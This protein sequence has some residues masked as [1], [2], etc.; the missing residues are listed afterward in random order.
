[1]VECDFRR[2][3]AL[4]LAESAKRIA[5]IGGYADFGVLSG[6]G[7]SQVQGQE[8]PAIVIPFINGPCAPM[9]D[10]AYHR[11]SPLKALIAHAPQ[12]EFSFN[13]G[14][15]VP[16]AVA[17]AKKADI[18]I[19]FATQWMSEGYDVADLS[20]PNGQDA[21]IAA[22]VSANPNTIVV[23]ETG[24]PVT[25]PWLDKTAAVVEAWYPGARGGEAI[26]SVLYGDTNP[27]G[28]LPVTFPTS[29]SQ[30]PHP[31]LPGSDSVEPDFIGKGKPGQTLSV[32][33]DVEGADVGYKWF[34]R[35]KAK[36]LFAFGHG[37][38][39]TRF[40]YSNLIVRKGKTLTAA[41]TITNTGDRDGMDAPKLYLI[42]SPTGAAQRLIAFEKVL[43]RPKES[44][45]ATV[46]LDPRLI[47][48]WSAGRWLVRN[49]TYK[50]ALAAS[51]DALKIFS[52]VQITE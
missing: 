32:D 20:L 38:S 13:D 48:R 2:G 39:Y 24:G 42:D 35:K 5:V 18:T 22:V 31:V 3:N 23:L 34:I 9:V 1:M 27:S 49:G 21:L 12:T 10:Q 41:F 19:I 8:G 47:G 6:T 50:F 14:R 17:A 25:M 28:R 44:R 40:A 37:L 45:T 46:T 36:P 29:V 15:Y 4:P 11:S 51:A 43:L 30:L 52:A 7:S 26:A 33:Y 16:S